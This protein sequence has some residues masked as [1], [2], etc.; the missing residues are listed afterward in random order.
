[1]ISE[2]DL[3]EHIAEQ[4]QHAAGYKQLVRELGLRGSER[5]ELEPVKPMLP[6]ASLPAPATVGT[7]VETA[8]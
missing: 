8:L 1:M 4:P 2:G 7:A 3:L 5:P 6:T